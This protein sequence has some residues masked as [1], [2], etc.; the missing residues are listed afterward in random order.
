MRLNMKQSW[1]EELV[2]AA[3]LGTNM[4]SCSEPVGGKVGLFAQY[5]M[6]FETND[7]ILQSISSEVN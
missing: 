6:N 2:P 7:A 5:P 3:H 4:A 1:G